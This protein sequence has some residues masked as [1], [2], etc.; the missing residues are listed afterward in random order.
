MTHLCTHFEATKYR[1]SKSN[2]DKILPRFCPQ[3]MIHFISTLVN[4][5]IIRIAGKSVSTIE[6]KI[7]SLLKSNFSVSTT[8]SY[9]LVS[10]KF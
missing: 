1:I 6:Q 2:K 9:T 4:Y 5:R 8:L 7:I 10:K 3:P